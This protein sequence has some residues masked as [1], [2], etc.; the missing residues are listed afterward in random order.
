MS[1]L[2]WLPKVIQPILARPQVEAANQKSEKL[3][4][5]HIL[6]TKRTKIR[7]AQFF[8]DHDF[9]GEKS[10]Q[11]GYLAYLFVYFSFSNVNCPVS[12]TQ[13]IVVPT[14]IRRDQI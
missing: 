7:N 14:I 10:V 5:V 12:V 8:T 4:R 2:E 9:T 3:Y 13:N 6:V 11:S 1:A